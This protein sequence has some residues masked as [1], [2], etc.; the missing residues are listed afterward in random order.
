M[1]LLLELTD[2]DKGETKY[3]TVTGDGEVPD[4]VAGYAL[5]YAQAFRGEPT[6]ATPQ[7]IAWFPGEGPGEEE[8]D[9]LDAA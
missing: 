6:E 4:L 2:L 3:I 7:R 9:G 8:G 5:R 1:R